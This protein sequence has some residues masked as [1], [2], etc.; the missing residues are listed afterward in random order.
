MFDIGGSELMV[1]LLGILILFG[2]DKLPD[3]LKTIRSGTNK[4][5]QAKNEITK[6]ITSI[7]SDLD[8]NIK[9][10]LKL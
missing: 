3:I 8:K 4:I 6:E 2:P 10:N 7:T 9:N 1:I 5:N